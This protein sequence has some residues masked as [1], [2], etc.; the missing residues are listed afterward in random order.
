MCAV[1]S[2]DNFIRQ[3]ALLKEEVAEDE[4]LMPA[5]PY[6]SES[7]EESEDESAKVESSHVWTN[8]CEEW[9]VLYHAA[10]ILRQ[11]IEHHVKSTK[12]ELSGARLSPEDSARLIPDKLFNFLA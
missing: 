1:S 6:C 4:P 5:D 2:T 7:G 9:R 8:E 3:F 12:Q 11:S 10:N